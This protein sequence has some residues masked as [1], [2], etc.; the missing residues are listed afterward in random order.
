[1][2]RSSREGTAVELV[3][4]AKEIPARRESL[5]EFIGCSFDELGRRRVDD[6]Q[7]VGLREGPHEFERA[8]RPRQ[9][10]REEVVDICLYRE[11][12]RCVDRRASRQCNNEHNDPYC[13]SRA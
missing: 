5:G 2:A 8:P 11:M 1:M 3:N 6:H 7:N 13:M 10:G 4:A 12:P 9:I